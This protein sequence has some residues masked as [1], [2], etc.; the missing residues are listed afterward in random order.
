[1]KRFLMCEPR[2]FEVRYVINPW[3]EG[4]LGKVNKE[5]AQQQWDNLHGL[6]SGMAPVD[7]IE[8]AGFLIDDRRLARAALDYLARADL[9]RHASWEHYRAGR[10]PG[11]A[12]RGGPTSAAS[13]PARC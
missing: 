4:N 2:F 10:R 3:M 9:A 13:W 6:L 7:L 5:L 11:A 1:M 12:S 8:P